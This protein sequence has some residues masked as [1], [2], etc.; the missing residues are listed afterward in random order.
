MHYTQILTCYAFNRYYESKINKNNVKFK[1]SSVVLLLG[2]LFSI[3]FLRKH[4]L[5]G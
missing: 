2:Y 1:R 4:I 5:P 3:G